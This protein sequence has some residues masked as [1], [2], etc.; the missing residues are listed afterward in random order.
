MSDTQ[1]GDI[2]EATV[3]P[4]RRVSALWL[5]PIITLLVGA[6]MVYDTWSKQGQL[7]TLEFSTAEGLEAGKTK[8]KT[9]EVVVGQV[10]EITLNTTLDGV[11][12][13]ARIN[14][15]FRHLLVEGSRFWVVQPTISLSGVSGLS[16]LLTGQFIRFSPGSGTKLTSHFTGLDSPPLTPLRTPGLRIILTSDGD[17]SFAKGDLIHYR[18]IAVGKIET[19]DI[20]FADRKIY[21]SAFIQAPYHQLITGETRFW[22]ASGIR[23]ELTSQG[24]VVEADTLDT[25]I[26]GGISFSTPEGQLAGETVADQSLFYVYPNRAAINDK[27]YLFSIRYWVMV[28]DSVG[29]LNVGAPVMHR[30]VQVGKVLRTDYVPDGGNLLDKTMDIPILIEINPGRLGLPDSEESLQRATADI[31][32]WISH[33]LTAIIKSQNLLLGQRM[34]SLTYDEAAGESELKFFKD[35]AVIPTG[36]DTI[37]K[38]TDSIEEFIAKMNHLPLESMIEKLEQMLEDGSSALA[39]IKTLAQSGEALVKNDRNAQLIEQMTVTLTS[40]DAMA[41]SFSGDSQTIQELKNLLQSMATTFEE[42]KPLIDE[43]KNKPNSLIFA[44]DRAEEAVPM[45]KQ[46]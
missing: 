4:L 23:A 31:N 19:V 29:G 6:W 13:T 42:L 34:V 1:V 38:F 7:I 44:P 20:N 24:L 14:N 15:E 37:D 9:R 3:S 46:P 33:G 30:G 16:T 25:V 5:I 41:Q 36:V 43:L 32:T 2:P 45:R 10:E 27:Q 26:L 11:I 40:I 18:G 21:Y 22:K 12:V 17:F 28:K 35:L 39:S 8:I